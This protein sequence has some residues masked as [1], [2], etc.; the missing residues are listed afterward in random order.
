MLMWSPKRRRVLAS[1]FSIG[2]PVKPMNEAFGNASCRCRA[3]P[4]MKSYWLLCASSAITTILRRSDSTGWRSP[5]SSGMN[6]WIVLNTTPPEPTCNLARKSVAFSLH[7][8]LSEEIAAARKGRE[9]LVVEIIAV[10]DHDD[11]RVFHRRVQDQPPGVE[12]H[13]QALARALRVPD[14]ADPLVPRFAAEAVAR[15]IG[16]GRFLGLRREIGGAQRLLDRDIGRVELVISRD[17]FGERA[18]AEILEHNEMADE[19]EKPARVEDA[20]EH[21]LQFGQARRASSRPLIVRHG[22]NHSLPVPSA[23]MRACTPSEATSAGL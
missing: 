7:R 12:G 3:R 22:L 6:F 8:F 20:G 23:P 5:F 18:A 9:Q 21:D 13:R 2:V 1:V 15:E 17:L 11:G 16:S 10:G 4:S 14:D 19:I